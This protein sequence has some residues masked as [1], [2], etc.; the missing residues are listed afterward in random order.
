MTFSSM[1]T[2]KQQRAAAAEFAKR[3]AGRGNE[4]SESE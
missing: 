4:K 1:K 3:W 2:D